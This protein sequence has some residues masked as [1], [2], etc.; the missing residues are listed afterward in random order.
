MVHT[1]DG[2]SPTWN[3]Q[4]PG[5]DAPPIN[6]EVSRLLCLVYQG[7]YVEALSAAYE[8]TALTP[9]SATGQLEP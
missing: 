1:E 6:I 9:Q 7:A 4:L 8:A 3:F 2:D 5:G